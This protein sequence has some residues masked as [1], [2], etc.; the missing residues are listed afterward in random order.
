MDSM[1]KLSHLS[2]VKPFKSAWSV[3]VKVIHKWTSFNHQTGAT[4]EMVLADEK[5]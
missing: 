2:D 3:R 5:V 4:L 1:I